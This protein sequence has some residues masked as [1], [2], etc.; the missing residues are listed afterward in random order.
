MILRIRSFPFTVTY[1]QANRDTRFKGVSTRTLAKQPTSQYV[2][3]YRQDP[4]RVPYSMTEPRSL[5]SVGMNADSADFCRP[6][7]RVAHEVWVL[8]VS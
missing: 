6:G 4:I 7:R 1:A 2:D 5:V 3:S 8:I